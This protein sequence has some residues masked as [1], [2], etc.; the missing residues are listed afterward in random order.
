MNGRM[1]GWMDGWMDKQN[2]FAPV[3]QIEC[4]CVVGMSRRCHVSLSGCESGWVLSAGIWGSWKLSHS[5]HPSAP[6][7][8]LF[9]AN[10]VGVHLDSFTGYLLSSSW[11]WIFGLHTLLALKHG[12]AFPHEE[13]FPMKSSVLSSCGVAPCRT[14]KAGSVSCVS[15][16][17]VGIP[18]MILYLPCL[19]K[20]SFHPVCTERLCLHNGT[21]QIP[22]YHQKS[23]GS[24]R[25]AGCFF[26]FCNTPKYAL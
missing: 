1:H 7:Q 4:P 2:W 19:N 17:S 24:I 15:R 8:V 9:K 14:R 11:L 6:F 12:H 21:A 26:F 10:D 13:C 18:A 23:V 16:T 20:V 25:C 3:Q 22:G 5:W